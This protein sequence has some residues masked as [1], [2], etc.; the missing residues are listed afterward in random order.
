MGTSSETLSGEDYVLFQTKVS[1]AQFFCFD[2]DC[3]FCYGLYVSDS[4]LYHDCENDFSFS[5]VSCWSPDEDK[6]EF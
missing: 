5:S 3:G 4:F 1:A 6:E 2:L